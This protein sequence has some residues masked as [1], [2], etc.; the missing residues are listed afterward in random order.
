MSESNVNLYKLK[1]R[2]YEVEADLYGKLG[3]LQDLRKKISELN[4]GRSKDFREK[5]QHLLKKAEF[6]E[7]G[8][9][10]K[11][12]KSEVKS[13]KQDT[14]ITKKDAR[15]K[16]LERRIKNVEKEIETLEAEL[17]EAEADVKAHETG[18]PTDEPQVESYQSHATYDD[19][20]EVE[21]NAWI[22]CIFVYTIHMCIMM[23][24]YVLF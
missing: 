13:M 10:D 2:Q 24:V 7:K 12:L 21:S 20:F 15:I 11:A 17:S 4:K 18:T 8:L 16:D 1:E 3:E 14:Q 5:E 6:E 22:S 23:W 19:S 9:P